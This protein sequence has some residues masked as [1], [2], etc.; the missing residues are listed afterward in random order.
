MNIQ[1][2][3]M[4]VCRKGGKVKQGDRI[5]YGHERLRV[6]KGITFQTS[7]K[8]FTIHIKE[9]APSA[10]RALADIQSLSKLSLETAMKLFY[11]NTVPIFNVWPG[12]SMGTSWRKQPKNIR[13]HEGNILKKTL[14]IPWYT[15]IETSI[16]PRI[17]KSAETRPAIQAASAIHQC[18]EQ[19][20]NT[21]TKE[22]EQNMV[23]VLLHGD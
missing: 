19:M 5:N 2:T 17:K 14:R 8:N 9:K 21:K 3:E 23:Q 7:G 15:S 16:R 6:A 4:M 10:V 12:H 11:L 13:K 20:N 22:G 1:K 18:S